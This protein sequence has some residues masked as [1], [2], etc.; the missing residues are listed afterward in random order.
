MTDKKPYYITTAIAYANGAPH[1]GHAY[2]FVVA[3]F[4]ARFKR[5]SGHEVF[6]QTGMDEF[7]QKIAQTA[8]KQ[9]LSPQELCDRNA[10]TF[11]DMT[12]NLCMSHDKF[13]RTTSKAHQESV[14]AI[15]KKLEANGDIYLDKYAG[16]YSVREEGY[17][18]EKELVTDPETGL[19]LTPNGTE[20][21]W[22]EEESFF[23]RLSAYEE[24]LLQYYE[25]SPQFI[26]PDTRRN[27][28]VSFV[29]GGLRDLC[30]SRTNFN[31]GVPVPGHDAHVMYVWLDA[32]SNYISGLDYPDENNERF[33]KFWPAADHVVGKDIIR[34]HCVYWPAFLMA[35]D[36][37]LP[38]TVFAHG[39]IN[40][41][42]KKMSK[43]L[44]NVVAPDRLLELFGV[45][46]LRYLLL[47]DIPSGQD[48]NYAEDH[49]IQRVNSDLSNGLGNL[50]QRSLSMIA[51][52]C[53]ESLPEPNTFTQ[54]DIAL[55]K[56]AQEQ[57]LLSVCEKFDAYRFHEA[58]QEIW[59]L[60]D[61]ANGYVDAQAPWALRKDDPERMKT[62]LYVLAE[63]VRCLGILIQPIMPGA[64]DKLLS[65]LGVDA[66]LR[67]FDHLGDTYALKPGTPIPKPQGVFPRIEV[68][69]AAE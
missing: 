1:I 4:M 16:W 9:G 20:V 66:V 33:R 5:L 52:N 38:E 21:E 34:F 47:R 48:G 63:T 58:L 64:A 44:G 50:A 18:D 3:D 13:I 45:D 11:E 67:S 7:G 24:R 26:V 40:V 25:Q 51:K 68:E 57:T 32:L 10:A 19:K 43:S 6:F 61:E 39:F 37:P 35:M 59:K 54:E 65:Q 14:Q 46:A 69:Q 17:F 62:V 8:E 55:L 36:L 22:V 42:G 56:R 30:V 60:V 29:K 28:I 31:W 27:E 41:A 23:F 53:D 49:A 2:E 15:W 12:K